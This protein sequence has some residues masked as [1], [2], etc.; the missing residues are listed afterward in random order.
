MRLRNHSCSVACGKAHKET[1]ATEPDPSTAS[2]PVNAKTEPS[3]DEPPPKRPRTQE[4]P[5]RFTVLE[6]DPRMGQLFL[7][8]PDLED[9]LAVIEK[10]YRPPSYEERIRTGWTTEIGKTKGMEALRAARG[11]HRGVAEYSELVTL[12]MSQAADGPRDKVQGTTQSTDR[13]EQDEIRRLMA[14]E[15]Q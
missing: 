6:Q 7:K 2:K 12:L 15:G 13:A 14:L 11:A 10:A 1:H 5:N 9:Q 8:Y 4:P 3:D